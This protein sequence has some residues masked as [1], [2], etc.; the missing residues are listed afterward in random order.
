MQGV[1]FL[2]VVAASIATLQCIK[3]FRIWGFL[4]QETGSV[5]S[6]AFFKLLRLG[7]QFVKAS[8]PPP[9]KKMLVFVSSL[10]VT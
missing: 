1:G 10:A 7:G 9:K 2:A 5:G 3:P 8:P 4:I 6:S